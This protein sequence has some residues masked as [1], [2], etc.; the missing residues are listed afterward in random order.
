MRKIQ[1]N[2]D[3]SA[4]SEEEE[5]TQHA[6]IGYNKFKTSQ[7]TAFVRLKKNSHNKLNNHGTNRP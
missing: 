3:D 4:T 5:P 7:T 6:S 1:E 2:Q